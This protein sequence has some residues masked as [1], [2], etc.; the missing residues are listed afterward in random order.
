MG[1]STAAAVPVPNHG[2]EA[3]SRG[4][5]S[6]LLRAPAA[7]NVAT[8]RRTDSALSQPMTSSQQGSDVHPRSTT[9]MEISGLGATAAA[10]SKRAT[11]QQSPAVVP[12]KQALLQP[13]L[14][15]RTQDVSLASFNTSHKGAPKTAAKATTA[16]GWGELPMPEA[17]SLPPTTQGLHAS[18]KDTG[19]AT[20]SKGAA[21][22]SYAQPVS[23]PQSSSHVPTDSYIPRTE[24][25]PQI[26]NASTPYQ[27][28]GSHSDQQP[29]ALKVTEGNPELSQQNAPQHQHRGG[30]SQQHQQQRQ[31]GSEVRQA[32]SGQPERK[33]YGRYGTSG[34]SAER[35]GRDYEP[36]RSRDPQE[37]GGRQD[38]PRPRSRERRRT[39]DDPQVGYT[40]YFD[41]FVYYIRVAQNGKYGLNT[42]FKEKI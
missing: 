21:A 6:S 5:T 8:T 9:S 11:S 4:A 34:G 13:V 14:P 27:A 37:E 17:L 25:V 28:G 3:G 31:T 29:V 12:F 39:N 18:L 41:I 30:G 36:D 10:S 35:R 38:V 7:P 2:I 40:W 19:V 42:V 23:A 16:S 33:S 22:Q 20:V 1:A 32:R 24:Q 26:W 15:S